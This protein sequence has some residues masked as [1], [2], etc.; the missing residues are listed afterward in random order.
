MVTGDTCPSLYD[1]YVH[2]RDHLYYEYVHVSV[3]FSTVSDLIWVDINQVS[4]QSH[5]SLISIGVMSEPCVHRSHILRHTDKLCRNGTSRPFR[6]YWWI[7]MKIVFSLNLRLVLRFVVLVSL[8]QT[9]T[10]AVFS[11]AHWL[12]PLFHW[13]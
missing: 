12:W 7:F 11:L 8:F 4:E 9:E 1:G 2:F 6:M 10:N 5:R 13:K 3:H